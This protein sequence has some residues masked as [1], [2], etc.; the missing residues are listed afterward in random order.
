[1]WYDADFLVVPPDGDVH[2]TFRCRPGQR[3]KAPGWPVTTV[4]QTWW[5]AFRD[6]PTRAAGRD[7]GA[8]ERE[9]GG[10]NV[11][12]LTARFPA[13]DPDGDSALADLVGGLAAATLH[14]LGP[15]RPGA[16]PQRTAP[17]RL[18]IPSVTS[19]SVIELG[20]ARMR[21][22]NEVAAIMNVPPPI[23]LSPPAS[24][25]LVECKHSDGLEDCTR[26]RHID[27]LLTLGG[28]PAP[29]EN[30]DRLVL[31]ALRSLVGIAL[32]RNPPQGKHACFAR[33]RALHPALSRRAFDRHVWPAFELLHPTGGADRLRRERLAAT[34]RAAAQKRARDA[35]E[36]WREKAAALAAEERVR[37]P[38]PLG[39]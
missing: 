18:S 9:G 13:V 11:G 28:L 36:R 29:A 22:H 24:S 21:R 8:A 34:G 16:A 25:V 35:D 7:A 32:G 31:R 38:G 27:L 17:H 4:H 39:P 33:V 19:G 37:A 26:I 10:G 1:M 30:Q 20:D 12:L 6:W 15:A 2:P 5:E 3:G 14:E 23:P